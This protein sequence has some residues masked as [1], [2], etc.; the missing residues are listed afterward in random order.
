MTNARSVQTGIE[1]IVTGSPAINYCAM[2]TKPSM[3]P[4]TQVGIEWS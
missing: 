1:G 2:Q 3:P 4:S